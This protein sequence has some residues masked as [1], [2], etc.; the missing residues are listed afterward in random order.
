MNRI[1]PEIIIVGAGIGG[2]R[3]AFDL[4]ESGHKVCLVERS[5]ATGGILTQLDHQFPNNH[6]G[7]CR[8]LP[9]IERDASS[10]FCLKKGLHH[11]NLL[12][13][14]STEVVSIDGAPG[15]YEVVLSRRLSGI[16]EEKCTN[17]MKCI[18][19]C[20]VAVPDKF[21]GGIGNRK[22]V[23]LP[24]PNR[25]PGSPVIDW[26]AC[27]RCNDCLEVCRDDAIVLDRESERIE[28]ANIAGVVLAT[29]TRLF[30][31][32]TLDVLGFGELPNVVTSTT[33][34]R[35][36][37]S[38]LPHRDK[39]ARP[40]D[41]KPLKKI[42]WI[43]CVGSRNLTIGADYCSSA[44]CMFSIKEAI[45]AA[46]KIGPKAET[47]IFY[48]DMRT[49]G[50]D[51]QRYRDRAEKEFGVRFV[52]CRIHSVEPGKD[53]DDLQLS[54]VDATGS[55]VDEVFDMVVLSAGQVP[56]KSLPSFESHNLDRE[57]IFVLGS[58]GELK[59]I[60]ESVVEAETMAGRIARMIRRMRPRPIDSVTGTSVSR[61]SEIQWGKPRFQVIIGTYKDGRRDFVD[62]N[63]I[64]LELKR[65]PDNPLVEM[66]DN[67]NDDEGWKTVTQIVK[68]AGANRLL[69]ATPFPN[70]PRSRVEEL[71]KGSN[72]IPSQ[73]EIIDLSFLTIDEKG[74]SRLTGAVF[75]ELEMRLNRLRSRKPQ[76]GEPV[77]I[78]GKALVIGSGPAGLKASAALADLD[79]EVLLVEK[80]TEI[81]G[82]A[83]HILDPEI[84]EPIRE[85]VRQVKEHPRIS[86]VYEAEIMRN[87]GSAGRFSTSIRLGSGEDISFDHS[88]AILATGGFA[89]E[90]K[91]YGLGKHGNI[92]SHF[93]LEKQIKDPAFST[94]PI[95]C[96]VMIQCSGSREEPNNYCSRTCCLKSL[97]NAIQIREIHPQAEVYV[98]YR[99]IMTYGESERIYTE[100]RRKGV[101]FLPFEPEGRPDVLIDS[102]RLFVEGYD[103][104]AGRSVRFQP[105]LISLATGMVP[106]K[107]DNLTKIFDLE[108]TPDG[109]VKE[110]DSKWRPVD[111][112]RE[113]IFVCGLAR[114]PMRVN[115]AMT[116]G[117]AAAQRSMRILSKP[118]VSPQR[119]T[120][121][122]RHSLC[123]HCELCINACP[124]R[125]RY[126]DIPEEKT[127]I[128]PVAC[129]GCGTC[130]AIC[131][132]G[133]AVVGDFEDQGIMNAI[134]AA[135]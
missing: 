43:Q 63:R 80:N 102:D 82:N 57:G 124:H 24:L 96:I 122:I 36:L 72:L 58:A 112:G 55:R 79:V 86:I 111:S 92:V 71:E 78:N 48:M 132:N 11:E 99:D 27:T 67:I 39:P 94:R 37:G 23:Y 101:V 116:E 5:P 25:N 30:D 33:F 26:E 22:A 91:A 109:F 41:Q 93:E 4:A 62:W 110:A 60:S 46:K 98:F 125:A 113:G 47:T 13:L 29:G 95:K 119:I 127:M 87:S 128:D 121:R 44:C 17:C 81:S 59:D 134:E 88:V 35:I 28:M 66:V 75:R 68:N 123:S 9:M 31:P 61:P 120:A 77:P 104:I 45:L 70:I 129:Q 97:K 65:L 90:P 100:A 117:E 114:A 106:N 7:M 69:M 12:V 56:E 105:D 76:G 6:C 50:R 51:F 2:I 107:I 73:V 32:G 10:Q 84:A 103:P 131:P 108:T 54:Y 64:V 115:E 15:R 42:A 34:E 89:A 3:T 38:S 14:P 40:S 126:F 118:V 49:F 21:S 135:L 133:A 53:E 1:E 85:I 83:S 19:A 8:M 130:A 16:D 52:R 18:A 20:S 74:P